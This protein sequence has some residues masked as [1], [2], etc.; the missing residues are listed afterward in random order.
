MS[1]GISVGT[2]NRQYNKKMYVYRNNYKN[3]VLFSRSL[4]Q[5]ECT[6]NAGNADD[7]QT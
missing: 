3:M 4:E 2:T 6:Q 5:F 1:V 7:R